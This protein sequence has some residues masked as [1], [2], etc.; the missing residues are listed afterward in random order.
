MTKSDFQSFTTEPCSF[1]PTEMSCIHTH[2]R[3]AVTH[4]ANRQAAYTE[5]DGASDFHRSPK[6]YFPVT[7]VVAAHHGVITGLPWA[8]V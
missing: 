6:F 2:T 3:K 5:T 1:T 7:M 4:K 8:L